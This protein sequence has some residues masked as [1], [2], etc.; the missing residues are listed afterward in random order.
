MTP[1]DKSLIVFQDKKIKRLWH[2]NEWFYSVTDILLVLTDS[3]DEMAYWRK[4]K[5]RESQLV[6]ICHGLKMPA[7][8]GRLRY[9]DCV[10]TKNAFRLIQ[11]IPSKKAEP[12]KQ[13][14][15]QIAK[16][17][18]EEIENPELAQDRLKEYYELKGYPKDWINKRLRGIA[19]RQELTDEWKSRGVNEQ[20][21]FAILTNEI[22]K[23]TFGKTVG[24]YKQFKG[25]KRPNQNLR[26]HMTDWELILNMVGEK[27]TTD[28]TIAKDAKGFPKLKQTAKEGGN[29][30]KNTRKELEQKVGK[31]IISKENYLHLKKEKKKELK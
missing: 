28:I 24:E 16:E 4:L 23:A 2:D 3:K 15:A 12:F 21:D 9:T 6:T 22:S 26:D 7:K 18:I 11:S 27:A 25:L 8:D 1:Q 31:S 29:I 10:N 17:R 30:A 14:L 19:I 20:K 13:W 5:Q